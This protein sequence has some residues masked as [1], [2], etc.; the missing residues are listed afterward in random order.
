MKN[1]TFS[2][3]IVDDFVRHVSSY[4][5]YGLCLC[6]FVVSLFVYTNVFLI[7]LKFIHMATGRHVLHFTN[8]VHSHAILFFVQYIIVFLSSCY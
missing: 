3:T 2:F 7:I 4:H 5:H 1:G 8:D 6:I